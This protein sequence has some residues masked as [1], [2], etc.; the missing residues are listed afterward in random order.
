MNLAKILKQ[1]RDAERRLEQTSPVPVFS[2][3]SADS[4]E[5]V[6]E[7][8]SD[9]VTLAQLTTGLAGK[10]DT[11]HAH[12]F[13]DLTDAPTSYTGQSGKLVAVKSTEDGL[14]LVASPEAAN[15]VPAGGTT[16]QLAA[17]NS[18]TDYDLKWV[19]APSAAN[20]IPT[21]GTTEQILSKIDGTDYNTHWVDK[22]TDAESLL[23]KAINITDFTGKDGYILAY[24]ETNGEFYLKADDGGGG[25][26][27]PELNLNLTLTSIVIS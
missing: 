19:D 9:G 15:G 14:E 18:N 16:N 3:G 17:K 22:P 11:D 20:G 23:T 25:G 2:G 5:G 4:I 1:R 12:K 21:G 26:S 6:G 7:T 10:S 27:L 13:T 24:D 8:I